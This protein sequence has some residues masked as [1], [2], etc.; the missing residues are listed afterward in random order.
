VIV[1]AHELA[2]VFGFTDTYLSEFRRD[3]QGH[4]TERMTVARGDAANRPD[5]LGMI[6]PTIL[7]RKQRAGA[8]S[9][10]DVARQTRPVRVWEEEAAIVLGTLGVSPPTPARPTPDSENFDPQVELDRVQGEGDARLADIRRR[11]ARIDETMRSLELAEE[12]MRLEAEERALSAQLA[13]PTPAPAP[14][15]APGTP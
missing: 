8:V 10:Q 3:R 14:A 9:A 12:I 13:A 11:R 7:E 15:P 1:V 4:T 5:L 6:D 2:H